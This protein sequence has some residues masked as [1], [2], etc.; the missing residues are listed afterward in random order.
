MTQAQFNFNPHTLYGN[1]IG[2]DRL[3]TTLLDATSANKGNYPPYNIISLGD[4]QYKVELALSG[5][6]EDDIEIS[7]K[8]GAL[9]IHGNAT[10]PDNESE[11]LH[12]GIC[13]KE[14]N[15]TFNLA[16]YVEVQNAEM[17]D[18]ILTILLERIVPDRLKPKVI[19]INKAKKQKAIK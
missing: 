2:I 15:R 14:F 19:A 11:Y 3:M 8:D 5:F 7:V 4:D 6:T 17:K 18:G 1:S 10:Q 9:N 16:D 13:N 12:K